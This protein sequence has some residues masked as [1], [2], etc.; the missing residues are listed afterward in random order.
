[1]TCH[2]RS[3]ALKPTDP[4][5][6]LALSET[7]LRQHDVAGATQAARAATTL[8]PDLADAWNAVGICLNAVG[9]FDEAARSFHRA[10]AIDPTAAIAYRGLMVVGRHA[11][12][13]AVRDRLLA[14]LARSDLTD[15]QRIDAGFALGDWFDQAGD[16][17]AAFGHYAAANALARQVMHAKGHRFDAMALHQEV[18]RLIATFTPAF[19]AA[20]RDWGNPS[21]L[22]IFAVGM[23]RSGSTLVEQ[24]LASH[25]AV[26]ARGESR[27]LERIA[28]RLTLEN[29]E[30]AER[31]WSATGAQRQ[32]DAHI[33]R[34]AA[35]AGG[36]ARVVDKM[37][38]NV[39][40]LGLAAALFPQ[41]RMLL[42]LRDPRDTCL[43]CFFQPFADPQVFSTDLLDCARRA[44]EVQR[45][46]AHW[47][48]VLPVPVLDVDVCIPG[49]GAERGDPSAGR[50]ISVC[51]G[52]RRAWTFHRTDRP[53]LTASSWQVRQPLYTGAIGRWRNYAAH[54]GGMLAILDGEA[55]RSF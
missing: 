43:S 24:I 27:D 42:C 31:D 1:M 33:A 39:F 22:P 11:A 34:L 52:I 51:P 15:D 53:I 41:S 5:L 26:V 37:P 29:P 20:A 45:L 12:G 8:A 19:F 2:R 47:Q 6:Q 54:L 17:D 48:S 18:D 23:P 14:L 9:Q 28:R 16:Y 50:L 3:I 36:A 7:L 13:P 35:F 30:R 38:D 25:P 40:R 4:R 21:A 44:R 10:L 49:A 46:M 32:A 55:S